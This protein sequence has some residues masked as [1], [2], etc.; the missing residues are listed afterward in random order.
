VLAEYK[1]RTNLGVGLGLLAQ[2]IGRMAIV[3]ESGDVMLGVILSLAGAVLFIWGCCA[4]AKGKGYHGAWGLLGL[5]SCIG[6]LILVCLTDKY[7]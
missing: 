6:L 2:I 1:T 3:S 4:Y 5:L 7:K